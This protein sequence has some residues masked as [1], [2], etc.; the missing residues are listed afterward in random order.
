M[1]FLK[2][3][4]CFSRSRPVTIELDDVLFEDLLGKLPPMRDI[5]R[6]IESVLGAS[7]P[8]LSHHRM[9]GVHAY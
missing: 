6:V 3:I 5:H 9:V 8:D 7:L 2:T 1:S 4:L